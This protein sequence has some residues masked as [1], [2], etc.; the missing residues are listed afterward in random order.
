M[1]NDSRSRDW[2]AFRKLAG[3]HG[4]A[5]KALEYDHPDGMP[6]QRE[7]AQCSPKVRGMGMGHGHVV[8]SRWT[9][10]FG[11][12]ICGWLSGRNEGSPG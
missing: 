2:K 5:R 12:Q 11:K 7:D 4:Q 3:A 1:L 10:T 8:L 9:N 6:E